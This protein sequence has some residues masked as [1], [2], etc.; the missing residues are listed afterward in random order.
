[1]KKLNSPISGPRISKC[2]GLGGR[3]D[4]HKCQEQ[5]ESHYGQSLL[6]AGLRAAEE[7]MG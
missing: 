4:Q 3:H 6:T 7:A 1:M 2:K 5:K